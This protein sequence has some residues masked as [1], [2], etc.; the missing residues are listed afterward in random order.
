MNKLI[1]I[2]V[3]LSAVMTLPAQAQ[4]G[5]IILQIT[6]PFFTEDLLQPVLDQY[7]ADNPGVQVQLVTYQ[8]FGMPVQDS[9]DPEEYLDNLAAYFSSADVLL[10]DSSLT[11]DATRA[12]YVLDLSPLTQSDPTYNEADF[13]ASLLRSFQWDAAQW[14]LPISTSFVVISYIPEAFDAAGLA[15]PSA[16]WTLDDL[17]YAVRTLTKY[18]TDGTV[19]MPGMTL[20]GF[21]GGSIAP[22]F[23]SLLGQ[24]VYSED[25][26]PNN[27]DF[28]SAQLE[29]YLDTWLQLV[30]DGLLQTPEGVNNNTVP[31]ILGTPIGFGGGGPFGNQDAPE[32]A[33]ALLPGG[34]AGLNVNGYAISRGTLYPD[35]AYDLIT[36]LVNQPDA[37]TASLGTMAAV[38]GLDMSSAG[39]PGAGPGFLANALF[40]DELEPLIPDALAQGLTLSESRFSDGI[41]TALNLM[42]DEGLDARTALDE[43]WSDISARLTA[44]DARAA[45]AIITVNEPKQP[46]QL[47]AGEIS[48]N[49]AL[50]GGGGPGGGFAVQEQWQTVADAFAASDPEVGLVTLDTANVNQLAEV[51]QNFDCFY[52]NTNLVPDADLS[53]LLNLDPLI[54]SDSS[55]DLDDFVGSAFDQVKA[56]DQ[57]WALPLQFSL[58]VLR[59]D[60]DMFD[61]ARVAPPQGS[62]TINEF[63]DAM[64]QIKLMLAE[65]QTPVEFNA[66]AQSS[67]LALIAAYGGLPFDTRTD[68]PTV[69][70]T[71]PATIDAIQQVLDLAN[72]GYISFTIGQGGGGFAAQA[73]NAIPIYSNTLAAFGFGG[74]NAPPQNT[75]GMVTFPLGAQF[76]AVAVNLGTGYI[77]AATQHPEACYRFITFLSQTTDLFQSMPARRSVINS[78]DLLTT[79]GAETVAFFNSLADLME[80]PTTILVPTNINAGNFGMTTWFFDV[81]Q[82]YIAGEV[83]DLATELQDAEQ[84]TRSYL[85]CLAAIPPFDPSQGDFQSFFDQVNACQAAADPG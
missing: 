85:E 17:D 52:S 44:A 51:T 53:Q 49:F 76:N 46:V 54:S 56:N 59:Y 47:V 2:I 60:Y 75:D 71:D 43:V 48:L 41:N 50:L 35:A 31:M 21:G 67:L 10:V 20:Q 61:A 4:D 26:F 19:A 9:D 36:Y 24:G 32:R 57:T 77:S 1:W 22:L 34:R 69:N 7:R 83:V 25:A 27:P 73:D 82:R 74:N 62:W 8:G 78:S 5:E 12:N 39:G 55:L 72:E 11:P 15:Y 28:S 16:A 70:F 45:G 64:R 38:V 14:A 65:D 42:Q 79:R 30:N 80:E 84:I 18:N 68:P 6:A 63:E 40:P 58:L 81:F 23:L 3:V 29:T 37:V 66:A 33:T 13:H